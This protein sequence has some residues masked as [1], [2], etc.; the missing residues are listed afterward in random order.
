MGHSTKVGNT[1]KKMTATKRLVAVGLMALAAN[2]A[3]ADNVKIG[4]VCPFSGGSADMGIAVRNGVRLAAEEINGAVGGV[5]GRRIE[6]VERDDQANP[7]MGKKVAEELVTKEKVSAV[8]GV[9]N[10]GVG[11]AALD[12]YQ[13]A[14]VPLLIPV[15]TGTIL[16]KK[17]APPAAP[18]NYIF[19]ISPRDELQ[20]PFLV[21]DA[22]RRG[23]Q[24]IA[25]F[26]D[27]TGYGEAGKNDFEKALAAAGM[28]AVAVL[29]FPIGV[30]DLTE[31]LKQ[32]RAAKADAL[33][34]F[35]LAS[36]AAV[37]V[38]SREKL[39][40]NVPLMGSWTLSWRS[41]MDKGEG[42]AEGTTM[43]QTFIEQASFERRNSFIASY[44]RTYN[45]PFMSSPMAAAQGYDAMLLMFYAMYKA[46]SVE[47]AKVRTALETLDRPVTGVITT[48]DKP[49][50][51]E[52]H[53]AI[54][55]NMLVM[56]VVRK[57]R[58]EYAYREDALK[59]FLVRRKGQ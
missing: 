13:N 4:V 10:T 33:V 18:E 30:K 2:A 58:V 28:Q 24:R 15:A 56:G 22:V 46:D 37:L 45:V 38:K 59:T 9:C 3:G 34:S 50:T 11:M 27:T 20:A 25:V 31:E 6:L 26:A 16:T 42:A 40:W 54:T 32:A 57:G 53:E 23:Y 5:N 17:F 48:Y 12:T 8:I 39:G 21:A 14:K 7:E 47:P 19:R 29:R 1:M 55:S 49:F 35:T 43:V 41:F 51:K 52:D 44:T 36:E